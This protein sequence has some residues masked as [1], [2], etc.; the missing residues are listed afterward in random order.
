VVH[1]LEN[2]HRALG[3]GGLLLDVLP[4]VGD[5]VVEVGCAGRMVRVG[6]VD[7]S[8][9]SERVR[10]VRAAL[11]RLVR[12]GRLVRERAVR[13]TFVSRADTVDDW[14]AH[15]EEKRSTSVLDPAVVE[16]ARLL[17][18][19]GAEV[20]RVRERVTATRYRCMG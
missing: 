3:P 11:A 18:A 13:F 8:H 20:L 12:R 2:V 5:A 16:R 14:L 7:E 1:A 6:E 9:R 17:L 19:E 10:E 4:D 15:R